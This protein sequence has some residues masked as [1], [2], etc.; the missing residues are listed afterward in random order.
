MFLKYTHYPSIMDLHHSIVDLHP[1]TPSIIDLH[2][3]II[4][5]VYIG[6]NGV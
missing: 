5:R 2:P 6:D 1:S 4:K 3:Y